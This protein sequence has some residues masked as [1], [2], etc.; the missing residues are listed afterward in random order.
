MKKIGLLGLGLLLLVGCQP[1]GGGTPSTA[2]VTSPTTGQS[3]SGITTVKV[4]ATGDV[5]RMDAYLRP[6][7]TQELGVNVGSA[8][9][10][11]YQIGWTTLNYPN[12]TTFDL[13]ALATSGSGAQAKSD[14]VSVT[15]NNAGTPTLTYLVAI[16]YP[17]NGLATQ[18]LQ[19]LNRPQ[20]DPRLIRAPLDQLTARIPLKA[21]TLTAQDTSRNN[22]LEWGWSAMNGVDGYGVFLSTTS[23]VGPYQRQISQQASGVGDQGYAVTVKGQ[24]GS[25]YFGTVTSITSS[26]ESGLSNAQSA[27]ILPEPQL[28]SPAQGQVVSDG[29][30]ILTWS[31]TAGAVGYL[32]YV[33]AQNPMTTPTAKAL[34]TN[35]PNT[36]PQLSAIY[37]SDK[38]ALTSGTYYWRVAAVGFDSRGKANSFS[39]TAVRSFSVP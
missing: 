1:S 20:I 6:S 22:D 31:P 36:T 5:A 25:T 16:S 17:V 27:V 12:Q 4:D 39:Y 29:R 38:N 9:S 13:Y 32:Y 2:K 35:Y 33:Y 28:A 14:L 24:P 11:P 30:P 7:G 10:A 34:W 19:Q 18:S 8:T 37:P 23:L 15:I 3:V 26:A 21:A